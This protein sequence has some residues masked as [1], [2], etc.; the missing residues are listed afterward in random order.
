MV[1]KPKLHGAWQQVRFRR[2]KE[3][4]ESNMIL[5]LYQFA[6]NLLRLKMIASL[7]VDGEEQEWR[8]RDYF[9]VRN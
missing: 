3:C 8:R 9:R 5:K 1:M 6:V 2:E 7:N 4:E